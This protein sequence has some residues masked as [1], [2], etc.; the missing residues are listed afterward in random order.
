M[1]IDEQVGQIVQVLQIVSGK[2]PIASCSLIP[3]SCGSF[4]RIRVGI[5]NNLLYPS[6]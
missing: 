1:D 4:H 2:E 5:T 3:I 6:L